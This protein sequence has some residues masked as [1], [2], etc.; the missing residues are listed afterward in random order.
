M[1]TV[2]VDGDTVLDVS[3]ER[4]DAGD[5]ARNILN[6]RLSIQEQ[7]SAANGSI[8][9]AD[10]AAVSLIACRGAGSP[11]E[12]ISTLVKVLTPGRANEAAMKELIQGCTRSLEEQDPCKSRS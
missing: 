12:D 10:H 7:K 8:A 6:G 9:Y 2:K 11:D 5:S 1:C 4:I 3:G